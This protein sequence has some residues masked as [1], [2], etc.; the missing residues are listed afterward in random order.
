[1]SSDIIGNVEM[2]EVRYNFSRYLMDFF[3]TELRK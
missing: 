1:V 3:V 2:R